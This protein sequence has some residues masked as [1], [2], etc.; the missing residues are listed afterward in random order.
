M[1]VVGLTAAAQRAQRQMEAAA[2]SPGLD[3]FREGETCVA[4]NRTQKQVGMSLS[5]QPLW[6]VILSLSYSWLTPHA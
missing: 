4:Q 6:F 3:R 2:R 1:E 5:E